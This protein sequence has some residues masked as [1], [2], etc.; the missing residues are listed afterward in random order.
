MS[1]NVN[2]LGKGFK[3]LAILVFLFIASPIALTMSF[4][5][6]K[7]FENTANESL[8]Y[9]ILPIA[10]ILVIFT[11]YFAFKTFKILLKAIFNK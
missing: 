3:Y 9:I 6:L 8:S 2:L 1:T 5:A 11:I 4:K 10:G 7:K